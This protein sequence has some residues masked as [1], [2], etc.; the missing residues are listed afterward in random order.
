M[1]R[2]T[3][4]NKK[5]TATAST[6]EKALAAVEPGSV[7][8]ARTHGYPP[9]P[10]L[11][12]ALVNGEAEVQFFATNDLA[13]LPRQYL[14]PFA[15]RPGWR[16]R[17]RA[18]SASSAHDN[19]AS[20]E[21]S[22]RMA[23]ELADKHIAV[24]DTL[25]C[26]ACGRGDDEEHMLIC[27]GCLRGFHLQCL[28]P[29]LGAMPEEDEWFCAA[30]SDGNEVEVQVV[31]E[32][33][34]DSDADVGD[35]SPTVVT[36]EMPWRAC[37]VCHETRHAAAFSSEQWANG[38]QRKC[39]ECTRSQRSRSPRSPKA[40]AS[41]M[42]A[43]ASVQLAAPSMRPYLGPEEGM[44]EMAAALAE[45]RLEAYVATFSH[46]GFDDLPYLLQL[47]GAA[48]ERV[49]DQAQMKHGHRVKFI[50]WLSAAA[51]SVWQSAPR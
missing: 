3:T 11:V 46:L 13:T 5:R 39:L 24:L 26:D 6:P 36:C 33:V 12:S 4:T 1:L 21:E 17:K 29:P 30:C 15:A 2:T 19:A 49:A 25:S 7:V 16:K 9:W 28:R 27:D 20:M 35:E 51:N 44:R 41:E 10:A 22:F 45:M 48:L 8:W 23:V 32:A 37:S 40:A 18:R 14:I 34:A 50:E 42:L 31:C 47:D 38:S 43:P